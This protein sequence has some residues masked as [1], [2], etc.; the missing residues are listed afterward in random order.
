MRGPYELMADKDRGMKR[1][2]DETPAET[3]GEDAMQDMIGKQLRTLYDSVLV[4]PI[5]DRIVELLL[6]LDEADA[7]R[8]AAKQT[9]EGDAHNDNSTERK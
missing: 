8:N 4:E 2:A 7:E 3:P 6:K 1:P 9:S 5:P